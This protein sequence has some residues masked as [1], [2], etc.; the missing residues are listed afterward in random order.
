MA[1]NNNLLADVIICGSGFAGLSAAL[2]TRDGGAEVI[3]L[4]KRHKLGGISNFVEGTYGIESPLQRARNVDIT[5]EEAFLSLMGYSHW[6]ANAALARAFIDKATNNIVW[7]QQMGAEFDDLIAIYPGGPQVWHIFKA[8]HI[9]ARG[10]AV[11]NVLARKASERGIRIYTDI[12]VKKLLTDRAKRISAV[13]AEDKIG[14][15]I[16]ANSK[17]VIIATGDFANNKKMLEE[18]TRYGNAA[19]WFNIGMTM[20]GDGIKMAW[21]EGAASE[22]LATVL[23]CFLMKGTKQRSNLR[24]AI[25][26]PYHLWVNKRGER[27]C[28]ED[29]MQTTAMNALAKQPDGIMYVIFDENTKKQIEKKG[30]VGRLGETVW[31]QS[32]QID[33]DADIEKSIK[34][35]NIY[36]ADTLLELGE[37]ITANIDTFQKTLD[38]YNK[39]CQQHYDDVFFKNTR[40]LRP[41][42]SQKFYAVKVNLTL[43]CTLG[44]IKINHKT[45][46]IDKNNHV[47]PG[48]YAVGNCAGGLYG[49][50]YDIHNITGG[51]S[52]FAI[53]SGRI[54]GENAL[55]YIGKANS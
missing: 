10:T 37:M 9:Q 33:L 28:A 30:A 15:T 20:T 45:E 32:K 24:N 4:E 1:K 41:V 53:G 17:A 49:D 23:G 34:D 5:K 7:L 27:F 38:E 31:D 18:H 26:E 3:V 12:A 52:A 43:L 50:T 42:L 44:G 48:L 22:G 29:I 46:V 40:Y 55:K 51:A 54:A 8:K 11:I 47:I 36:I 6:Q 19:T 39:C 16:Q 13:I 14:N 2:T 25:F 21:E 35:G